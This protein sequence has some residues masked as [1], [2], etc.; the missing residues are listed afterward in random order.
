MFRLVSGHLVVNQPETHRCYPLSRAAFAS[1]S[2]L[3]I[4]Y[5][6]F[7][8]IGVC[9]G[10]MLI[11]VIVAVAQGYLFQ[12]RKGIL[13]LPAITYAIILYSELV[14]SSSISMGES[15]FILIVFYGLFKTLV[16]L[17]DHGGSR[18]R[19]F[20]V[21]YSVPRYRCQAIRQTTC[22]IRLETC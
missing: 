9:L 6:D 22:R 11:G 4:L 14:L 18:Q 21:F 2:Y 7:G 1:M 3:G 13:E 12:I 5:A 17:V 16:S 8:P 20:T 19:V 15:L 10:Y